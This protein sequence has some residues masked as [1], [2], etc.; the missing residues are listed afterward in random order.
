DGDLALIEGLLARHRAETGSPLAAELLA[1]RASLRSRFTR[2]LPTGFARMTAAI[3][4]AEAQG[5]DPGGA[6]VWD[7]ILEV[8]RG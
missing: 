1:D 8:S 2:V 5:L 7:H 6:G 4:Q 3:A